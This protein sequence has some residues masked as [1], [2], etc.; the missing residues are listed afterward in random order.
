M[1][2]QWRVPTHQSVLPRYFSPINTDSRQVGSYHLLLSAIQ[3]SFSEN[4]SKKNTDHNGQIHCKLTLILS[5][6]K[7][8]QDFKFSLLFPQIFSRSLWFLF[9]S[10]PLQWPMDTMG[11]PTS[12]LPLTDLLMSPRRNITRLHHHTTWS[13]RL[14]KLLTRGNITRLHHTTWNLK[15]IVKLQLTT[16]RHTI[17][18]N[19]RTKWKPRHTTLNH[20]RAV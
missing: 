15:S 8:G 4:N 2:H 1:W 7:P 19:P 14:T 6:I 9:L 3:Y 5:L 20:L 10:L 12:S 18:L 13:P 11:N 17:H 16:R